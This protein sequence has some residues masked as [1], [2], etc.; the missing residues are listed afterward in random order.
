MV[1]ME[2]IKKNMKARFNGVL[3]SETEYKNYKKYLKNVEL[4]KLLK[5][6]Y[7]GEFYS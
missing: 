4:F 6:E 3:L 1:F 7:Y 2:V 5:N